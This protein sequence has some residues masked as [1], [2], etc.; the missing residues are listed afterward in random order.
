VS[1]YRSYI[2]L[3]PIQLRNMATGTHNFQL[4]RQAIEE[5]LRVLT[6]AKPL[7]NPAYFTAEGSSNK[8]L[9]GRSQIPEWIVRRRAHAVGGEYIPVQGDGNCLAR[10]FSVILYGHEEHHAIIRAMYTGYVLADTS[11]HQFIPDFTPHSYIRQQLEPVPLGQWG[12]NVE[13]EAIARALRLTVF[14]I[15][16]HRDNCVIEVCRHGN[17][18][19]CLTFKRQNHYD[20]VGFRNFSGD[21][22][23]SDSSE[24]NF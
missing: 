7:F 5:R 8:E 2:S 6:P 4:P 18:A 16:D 15:T 9:Q 17:T 24:I 12:G 22:D 23:L 11:L 19:C 1:S 3:Y 21:H 13:L 20:A 10:A 14:L